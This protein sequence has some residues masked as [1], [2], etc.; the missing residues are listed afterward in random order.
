MRTDAPELRFADGARLRTDRAGDAPLRVAGSHWH[1]G[2]LLVRFEG[3]EDRSGAE[4]LAGT[5]LMIAT[6]E[7]GAA[8]DEAWWDADLIGLRAE[9]VGG[10]ALGEVTDV[11]H[12]PAQDL[13]VVRLPEGREV[14]VP[15]V[16]AVVPVVDATGGRV[17]LAPPAGL[18]DADD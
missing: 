15:F 5:L 6:H 3:I 8:G 13:L 18:L 10:A 14:L 7:R 2:R 11:I 12:A 16:A 1:S 17:V 9:A 4:A